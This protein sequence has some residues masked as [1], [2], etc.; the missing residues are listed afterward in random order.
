[1]G[2]SRLC[3][4]RCEAVM[5]NGERPI[6]GAMT[7]KE[8]YITGLSCVETEESHL[9]KIIVFG[10]T[11]AGKKTIGSDYLVIYPDGTRERCNI[12]IPPSFFQNINSYR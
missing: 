3:T 11:A 12:E 4:Y 9:D 7:L 1:M 8:A 10:Q 5:E 2:H 6:Y